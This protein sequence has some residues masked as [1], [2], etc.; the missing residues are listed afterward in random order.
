MFSEKFIGLPWPLA[1]AVEVATQDIGAEKG[2]WMSDSVST[3][4]QLIARVSRMLLF[5]G[6][7]FGL[8]VSEVFRHCRFGCRVSNRKW[9]IWYLK[10]Y[11]KNGS[12]LII[13]HSVPS[14]GG[15]NI[16]LANFCLPW[17]MFNTNMTKFPT[18]SL[19]RESNPRPLAYG[20]TAS[21][22]GTTMLTT[23]PNPLLLHVESARLAIEGSTNLC[24][25]WICKVYRQVSLFAMR[26]SNFQCFCQRGKGDY[27][28]PPQ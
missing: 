8:F 28:P 16:L 7:N 22:E 21:I 12:V 10:D 11:M 4:G 14:Q 23:K 27:Y 17:T 19:D 26:G 1:Q 18:A 25:K 13:M 9:C 2:F 15:L 3:S 5:R 20:N 24:A 6:K